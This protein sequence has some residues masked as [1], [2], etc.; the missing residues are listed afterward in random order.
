MAQTT[1]DAMARGG[2]HDQIGGG[3]SRYSTDAKWLVPHFEK[4]L[5]DNALLILTYLEAY[6]TSKSPTYAEVVCKTADYI[7][8]ELTDNNGGFYC[9]QDADS[10]GVEGKYYVFTPDEI[11]HVLGRPDGME[12]CRLY[13]ITE[14]GNFE[15]KSIPN[16]IC[17]SE[18]GWNA[19]DPRLKALQNFRKARTPLH[20]DDKILLSWNAWTVIALSRAGQIL[21]KPA[22]LNAAIKAQK[23]IQR[24]MTDNRDRLYHRFRDAEAAMTASWRTMPFTR[25]AF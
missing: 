21:E 19:T 7:L 22:Y 3:F 24:H 11:V 4:M 25:S 10:D 23:F 17:Q 13:N 2:I 15:G 18:M 12:F 1:L 16:R 8:R 6:Q 9:G 20:T 5:Y 14:S